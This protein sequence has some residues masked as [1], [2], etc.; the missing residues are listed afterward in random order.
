MSKPV[1][2]DAKNPRRAGGAGGDYREPPRR[3]LKN[4][5]HSMPNLP[6]ST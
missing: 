6:I 3:A 2:E 1:E 5:H 4:S